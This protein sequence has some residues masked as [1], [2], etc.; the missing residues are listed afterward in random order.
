MFTDGKCH[1]HS[2]SWLECP[3]CWEQH[4]QQTSSQWVEKQAAIAAAYRQP[5]TA[6]V[7]SLFDMLTGRLIVRLE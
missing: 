4:Q 1:A 3:T 6:P 5:P 7:M 2:R